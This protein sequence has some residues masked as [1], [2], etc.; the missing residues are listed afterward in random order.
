MN[1]EL[2]HASRND[3]LSLVLVNVPPGA[4]QLFLACVSYLRSQKT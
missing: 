1:A 3:R 2:D 4:K